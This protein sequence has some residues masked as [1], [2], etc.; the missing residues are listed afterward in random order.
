VLLAIMVAGI[1]LL[2][3]VGLLSVGLNS[4]RDAMIETRVA[5]ATTQCSSSLINRIRADWAGHV[6]VSDGTFPLP[7]RSGGV[8]N[9]DTADDALDDPDWESRTGPTAYYAHGNRPGLYKIENGDFAVSIRAWQAQTTSQ[10]LASGGGQSPVTVD[11]SL[12]VDVLMEISW[13]FP[14]PYAR[15]TRWLSRFTV[16]RASEQ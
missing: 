13:P 6:D 2:G 5:Q 3:I 11:D 12:A 16:L 4:E 1:G 15:R 9:K 14:V 10:T 8:Y 7:V